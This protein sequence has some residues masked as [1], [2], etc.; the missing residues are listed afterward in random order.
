LTKRLKSITSR[1]WSWQIVYI[2]RLTTISPWH[3]SE[4]DCYVISKLQHIVTTQ[5]C[6]SFLWIK[7]EGCTRLPKSLSKEE[8]TKLFVDSAR[9]HAT[10]TKKVP[11]ESSTQPSHLAKCH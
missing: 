6:S 2:T 11:L 8:K 7:Y 1:F 5:I 3:F 4:W 9:N 10:W